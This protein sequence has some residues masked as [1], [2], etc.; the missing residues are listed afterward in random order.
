MLL[1]LRGIVVRCRRHKG[2]VVR[3]EIG[4]TNRPCCIALFQQDLKNIYI[5]VE[6]QFAGVWANTV[7]V[8]F[9]DYL[10]R[11]LD[12]PGTVFYGIIYIIDLF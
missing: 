6:V 10:L 12:G 5:E 2:I 11:L 7:F 9:L 1:V 4:I 8:E 3:E